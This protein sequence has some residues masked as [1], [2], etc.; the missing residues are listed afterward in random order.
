[1][2]HRHGGEGDETVGM[3][4]DQLGDDPD[5]VERNRARLAEVR[6]AAAEVATAAARTV[7]AERLDADRNSS[8]AARVKTTS[9][10]TSTS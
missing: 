2:L 6:A 1:M 5:A 10:L 4:G 7:L 3:R 9:S 8:S